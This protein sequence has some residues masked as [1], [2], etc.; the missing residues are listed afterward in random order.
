[1]MRS[2]LIGLG[3]LFGCLIAPATQDPVKPS[4]PPTSPPT[5]TDKPAASASAPKSTEAIGKPQPHPF[6]GVYS[7]RERILDGKAAPLPSRG[8]L[9]V[10]NR[11]MFLCL[12]APGSAAD[13][14]LLRA[15]AR[16]WVPREGGYVETTVLLGWG[17]DD[18]GTIQFEQ[19]GKQE[20]RRMELIRGGVRVVQD[21]RNW[22]D[23]ERIE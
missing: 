3:V 2:A 7:L 16:T 8:Y 12:G 9:C 22:L 21:A 4:A 23:F 5:A 15:G 20:R 18:A 10:T 6:E 1:M 13:K 11:H 14:V 19:G 17:T